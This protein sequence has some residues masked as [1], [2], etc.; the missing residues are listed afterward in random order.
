MLLLAVAPLFA[1]ETRVDPETKKFLQQIENRYNRTSTLQ[2]SFEE[3]YMG[4]GRPRRSEI[5]ELSL[6]KPGRMRW[7]YSQPAG[8]LFLSDNK[9]IYYYNP[10]SKK[11]EKLKLKESDD[12]RAP[13][14][15]L[16]GRLDFNKD[17]QDFK[18]KTENGNHLLI[19]KPKSDKSPYKQVEFTVTSL[20]EIKQLIVSGHDDAVLIFRFSNERINPVLDENLFRFELPPGASWLEASVS[21]GN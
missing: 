2:V 8:K 13:L 1:A 6:R 5:G 19:A 14:A 16:L 17:F 18:L 9:L 4:S 15:F 10:I 21:E 3:S 20:G 7:E 11:A 12:M